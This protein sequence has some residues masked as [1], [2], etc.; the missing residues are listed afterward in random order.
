MDFSLYLKFPYKS[1]AGISVEFHVKYL[2]TQ[3]SR[4]D[5][6]QENLSQQYDS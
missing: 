6:N 4:Q 1:L 5:S 2:N 3:D